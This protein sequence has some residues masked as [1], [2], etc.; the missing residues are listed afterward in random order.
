MKNYKVE[1]GTLRLGQGAIVGLTDE[2]AAPRL[3]R[4]SK[5]SAGVYR[6][7]EVL[8]FKNGEKIKVALDDIPKHARSIAVCLDQ[9]SEDV[10]TPKK[11]AK[12][13]A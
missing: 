6:L 10:A 9:A 3:H 8:E 1:G 2:Q 7:D 11:R 5:V 13:E 12:A 4:M